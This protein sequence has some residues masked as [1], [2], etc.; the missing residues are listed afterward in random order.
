MYSPS[1]FV[2]LFVFII[3]FM[4]SQDKNENMQPDYLFTGLNTSLVTVS[5]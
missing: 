4:S 2:Y 5:N 3:K 1:D